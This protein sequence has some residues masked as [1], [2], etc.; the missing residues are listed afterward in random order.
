MGYEVGWR[1]C[2]EGETCPC[3]DEQGTVAM[4]LFVQFSGHVN[5]VT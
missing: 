2:G 1:Y 5:S 4:V 3:P